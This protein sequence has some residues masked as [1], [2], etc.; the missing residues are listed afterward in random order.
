MT[1]NNEAN[2]AAWRRQ[3]LG[4]TDEDWSRWQEQW[5]NQAKKHNARHKIKMLKF[6]IS[7]ILEN[8]QHT[9]YIKTK[10]WGQLIEIHDCTKQDINTILVELYKDEKEVQLHSYT[11]GGKGLAKIKLYK[12]SV[13]RPKFSTEFHMMYLH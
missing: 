9:A 5:L 13:I 8:K 11:H 10:K 2:N 12:G 4:I 7:D 3:A 1:F 6:S